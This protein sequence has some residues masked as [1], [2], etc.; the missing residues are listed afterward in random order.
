MSSPVGEA[1]KKLRAYVDAWIAEFGEVGFLPRLGNIP[2]LSISEVKAVLEAWEG[3]HEWALVVWEDI[4]GD[5]F[6]RVHKTFLTKQEALDALV[7]SN[8]P[9]LEIAFWD[10]NGYKSCWRGTASC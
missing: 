5:V 1:G 2:S 10:D 4:D 7:S 6:A 3:P 8:T 9:N